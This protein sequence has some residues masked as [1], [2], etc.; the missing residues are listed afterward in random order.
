MCFAVLSLF[1]TDVKYGVNQQSSYDS[2][3]KEDE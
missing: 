1:N 2:Y 3:D